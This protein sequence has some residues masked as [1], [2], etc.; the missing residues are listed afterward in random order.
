MTRRIKELLLKV[1]R[2]A[3]AAWKKLRPTEAQ[4][5]EAVE[6]KSRK[7]MTKEKPAENEVS[8]ES[9]YTARCEEED[10]VKDMVTQWSQGGH[11]YVPQ[12]KPDDV[13]RLL[14]E[15]ANSLGIYSPTN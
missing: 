4:V 10:I 14:V 5:R 12:E 15:N 3:D 11:G 6:K 7:E 2:A 8:A 9:L 13:L 1:K